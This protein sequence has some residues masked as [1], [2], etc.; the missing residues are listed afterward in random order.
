MKIFRT[1]PL[2]RHRFNDV[3]IGFLDRLFIKD[4]KERPDF[5][6]R[7]FDEDFSGVFNHVNQHSRRLFDIN[8]NDEGLTARLFANVKT[9]YGP[10]SVDETIREWIEE[11]VRSLLWFGGTYYYLSDNAERDDIHIASFGPS[12]VLY[13][14]GV[15]FQWVP[16]RRERHW[17][18]DDEEIPREIRILD[19]RK[20]MHFEMPRAIKRMLYVQ[21]RTL[22][23]LDRHQFSVTDFQVQATHENPNPTNHFDFNNWRDTQDRALYRSTRDTGWSGRKCDSSKHSDFF[24]CHRLIR[25]RR[26]QLVL[27]DAI[28]HRLSAELTRVGRGYNAQYNIGISGTD[29]LP[30]VEHLDELRAKLTQEEVGFSEIVDFCFKR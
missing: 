25:F 2:H 10:H 26:N 11:I 14:F 7:M 16:K 3:H 1:E 21:N 19:S 8:S 22:S 20:V 27:R 9:R 5:K 29:E 12:G 6:R 30:S 4:E 18:G 23:V 13:L 17:D 15:I 24:D 28:L